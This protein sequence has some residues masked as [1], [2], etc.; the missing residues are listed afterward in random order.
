MAKKHVDFFSAIDEPEYF[1]GRLVLLDACLETP[2]RVR[3]LLG[4]RRIGKTSFLNKFQYEVAKRT[5]IAR[6]F[7]AYMN[8]GLDV[9]SGK[10][11]LLNRLLSQLS[12][13]IRQSIDPSWS[14]PDTVHSVD[15]FEGRF[16]GTI[17]RAPRPWISRSLLRAG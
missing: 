4:G 16:E 3:V 1:H 14:T 15:E 8:I 11:D 12:A 7:M 5:G 13:A 2:W 9:P 10:L 6:V 17:E